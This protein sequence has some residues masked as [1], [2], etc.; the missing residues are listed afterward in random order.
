MATYELVVP[1]LLQPIKTLLLQ[2]LLFF[3]NIIVLKV[4]ARI[5]LKFIYFNKWVSITEL[6]DLSESE[7]LVFNRISQE[8][9][10]PSTKPSATPL[11]NLAH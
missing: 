6:V 1:I 3:A 2:F 11:G 5:S 7:F 4:C 8:T 10:T 9:L